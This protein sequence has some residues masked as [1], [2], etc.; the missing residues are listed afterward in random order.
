MNVICTKCHKEQ[1]ARVSKATPHRVTCIHC[2]EVI[3]GINEFT[4]RSLVSQKKFVDEEKGQFSFFC[5]NCNGVFRG[6]LQK[7]DDKSWVKCPSCGKKMP[8][9]SDFT[10]R[11]MAGITFTDE[12]K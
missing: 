11:L 3:G 4:V 8:N 1:E 6:H 7:D 9:V 2:G 5:E 12:T 10:I